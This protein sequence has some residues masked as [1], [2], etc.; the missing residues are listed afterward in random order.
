[1]EAVL[2]DPPKVHY[3]NDEDVAL[4]HQS[5]VWA[6]DRSCYEFL[7][8]RCRAGTAT[9][10]TGAG[11]S[12]ALFAAWGT[13][14]LCVTPGQQ[15]ADVLDRYCERMGFDRRRLTFDIRPSDLALPTLEPRSLD[16]FLID[17]NHGF[18]TPMI[19]WYYG[20]RHL[21]VGGVVV[22]DDVHL[23]AVRVLVDYMD[24][25]SRWQREGGTA[26]WAAF[27]RRRA[28]PLSEDWFAQPFYQPSG[29]K[30]LMRTRLS[31]LLRGR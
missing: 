20:A 12:T 25:D 22:V 4:G 5:G 13:D 15:E 29:L 2:G 11:V 31:R 16:L 7:A 14:H 18:P 30:A 26:K 19:D 23:P 1:M 9:L 27:L 3:M 28:E 21:A 10:E 24:M 17:G 8:A 6:T